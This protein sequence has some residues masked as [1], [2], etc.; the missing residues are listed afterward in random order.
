MFGLLP[1]A[2]RITAQVGVQPEPVGNPQSFCH[3]A[4]DERSI[5]LRLEE[6][7]VLTVIDGICL[8]CVVQFSGAAV[9]L[10]QTSATGTAVTKGATRVAPAAP[11][12]AKPTP[13]RPRLRPSI[14]RSC[15]GP[16]ARR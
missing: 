10:T 3:L 15:C 14:E 8:R 16:C 2:S 13:L 5:V 9:A 6:D 11:V 12:I 4:E 1:A 7:D